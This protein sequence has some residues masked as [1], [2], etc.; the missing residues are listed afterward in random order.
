MAAVGA[1]GVCWSCL[2]VQQ[3]PGTAGVW[4]QLCLGALPVGEQVLVQ[5]Q[6]QCRCHS[7][8]ARGRS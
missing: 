8:S 4:V 2:V 7:G 1:S 5:P 6:G 3:S